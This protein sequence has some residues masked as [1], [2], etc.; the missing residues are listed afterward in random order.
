MNLNNWKNWGTNLLIR[1]GLQNPYY[2][3]GFLE[4]DSVIE[5]TQEE[6]SLS[7]T[8]FEWR[9]GKNWYKPWK[10]G[11]GSMR[12]RGGGG[13]DI[14]KAREDA[15]KKAQKEASE[16]AAKAAAREKALADQVAA[17]K[18]AEEARRGKIATANASQLAIG[19]GAQD[20]VGNMKKRKQERRV[21][22]QQTRKTRK[23]TV[24]AQGPTGGG[25][26]GGAPVV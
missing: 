22:T 17:M 26:Y 16:A 12:S 9:I 8:F 6:D 25:A 21:G 3:H 24:I 13:V 7:K 15:R 5:N 14:D 19:P 4:S 20:R 1:F 2:A 23:P 18:A 11:G 10:W